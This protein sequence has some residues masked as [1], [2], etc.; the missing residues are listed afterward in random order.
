MSLINQRHFPHLQHDEIILFKRWLL[1]HEKDWESF[2][3]DVHVGIGTVPENDKDKISQSFKRLTQK[4]I[5]VVA[6]RTQET[7]LIEI[8]PQAD[9]TALG[10][11]L[12]Y[13]ELFVRDF[14][15]MNRIS[16]LCITD[17]I[18]PDD[19]FAIRAHAILLEVV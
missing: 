17:R 18:R 3:F 10:N 16:L 1:I 15:P 12:A 14:K 2:E 19:E 8:R 13:K 7:C 9:H 5:D 11:L 4:R 6:F